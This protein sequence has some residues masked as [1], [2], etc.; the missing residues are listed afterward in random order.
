MQNGGQVP[1]FFN[2]SI[3]CVLSVT[4]KT[5][6]R[7]VATA[8]N[9][10]FFLLGGFDGLPAPAHQKKINATEPCD[11]KDDRGS[12]FV[13]SGVFAPLG[14]KELSRCTFLA[15]Q[16]FASEILRACSASWRD[17]RPASV[18]T[19]RGRDSS[20]NDSRNESGCASIGCCVSSKPLSG[21]FLARS[22]ATCS[23]VHSSSMG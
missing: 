2:F 4:K 19:N 5:K 1:P 22:A 7:F 23:F 13:V 12:N 20:R 15:R 3:V 17:T 21:D 9:A 16:R 14:T 6:N 18:R 11:P 10:D 8:P